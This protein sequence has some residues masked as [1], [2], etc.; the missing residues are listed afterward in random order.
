MKLPKQVQPVVR[1]RGIATRK[2]KISSMKSKSVYPLG[3]NEALAC[4]VVSG[5][6]PLCGLAVLI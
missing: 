6:N 5:G 4:A 2:S 1:N 3:V